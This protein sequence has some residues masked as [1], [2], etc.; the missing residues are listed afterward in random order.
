MAIVIVTPYLLLCDEREA[1]KWSSDETES[2]VVFSA[3]INLLL[4]EFES[5]SNCTIYIRIYT[6]ICAH[7]HT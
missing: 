2:V 3:E 1:C 5:P 4:T 7:K 6:C